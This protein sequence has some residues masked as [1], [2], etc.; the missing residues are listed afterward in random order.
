LAS[1][2]K[3]RIDTVFHEVE[4]VIRAFEASIHPKIAKTC[5]Q[6]G[7]FSHNRVMSGRAY[8]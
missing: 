7:V 8:M 4:G 3:Q 2:A 5:R 6:A 1:R